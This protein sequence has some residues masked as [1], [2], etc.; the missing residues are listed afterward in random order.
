MRVSTPTHPLLP[1]FFLALFMSSLVNGARLPSEPEEIS[2]GEFIRSGTPN[3]NGNESNMSRI[4][5]E[6]QRTL[7]FQHLIAF[8]QT[9]GRFQVEERIS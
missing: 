3:R 2:I 4:E 9:S 8:K 6:F 5:P 1:T 7:S